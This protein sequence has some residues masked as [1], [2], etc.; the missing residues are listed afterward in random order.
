M[1]VHVVHGEVSVGESFGGESF[2]SADGPSFDIDSITEEN[3]L[4]HVADVV[5]YHFF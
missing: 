2:L 1:D 4:D 3:V 5:P